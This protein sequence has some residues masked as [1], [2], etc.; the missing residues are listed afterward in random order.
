MP[1]PNQLKIGDKIRLLEVPAADIKQR[2]REIEHRI[3]NPGWTANTIEIIIQQDPIVEI[4]FIDEYGAPW[5]TSEIMVN[6][7]LECHTIA[8]LDEE[9]WELV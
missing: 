3:E 1:N 8:I 4:D 6:G 7:T 5:Y 2:Q 9:S